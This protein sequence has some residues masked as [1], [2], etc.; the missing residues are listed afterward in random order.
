MFGR[1][2]IA[3]PWDEWCG[4]LLSV[5]LP[6]RPPY[7]GEQYA[8]YMYDIGHRLDWNFG[9]Q[10]M[11]GRFNTIPREEWWPRLA[12]LRWW[13]QDSR[14][15]EPVRVAWT[16]RDS[17]KNKEVGG[18]PSSRHLWCAAIDLD[19]ASARA[20]GYA[21]EKAEALF[22][23]PTNWQMGLG[24]GLRRIHVDFFGRVKP[25]WWKYDSLE[26]YGGPNG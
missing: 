22:R 7:K 3:A 1:K 4:A 11:L 23:S 5:G 8:E 21:L 26:E 12:L 6:G 19:Y 17:A 2:K 25:T 24:V 13:A 15:D 9:I 10:E 14:L 16:W 20:H 18:A